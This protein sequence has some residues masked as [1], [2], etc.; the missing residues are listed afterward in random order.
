MLPAKLEMRVNPD[1]R[2]TAHLAAGGI[3]LTADL[4]Q[5]RILRRLHDRARAAAG[6]QAWPTAQVLPLA[7]W[8]EGEW[9]Q[10][11]MLR[12]ELPRV[13]PPVA[14]DWLWRRQVALAEPSLL[15]SADL[16]RR[17]RASWL[18]LQAHGSSLAAVTRWPLT[19]DQQAFLGWAQA[20]EK[21]LRERGA[22]DAAD[23]ARRFVDCSV[24][25]AAGPPILLA[26]FARVTPAEE[27]LFAAL[28]TAGRGIARAVATGTGGACSRHGARDPDAERDDM[29]AWLRA[30]V[31]ERPDGI[32]AVIVADLDASRG[33]LE[34]ALAASLQ[35]DLE[36]PGADR[37]ERV[38]DLAGGHTLAM[39]P[40][41]DAALSALAAAG[42]TIEWTT[43]S[44]LLRS[45]YVAGAAA[46][47]SSRVVADLAL[48]T[49]PGGIRTSGRWLA[50]CAARAGAVRFGAAADAAA[51]ALE[52]PRRRNA[53][54]WA[55]AFGQCLAAWGWPGDRPPGSRV[56]QAA[57]RLRELLRE[58]AALGEWAAGLSLGEALAELRRLAGRPFQPESGEPAVYV[59][60]RYDDP[61]VQLDSLWV[62]GLTA[63]AWPR[64]VAVDPLLPIEIQRE[65][66]LPGATPA[67]RVAEA[68]EVIG[69]WRARAQELVL[70]WPRL[71]NDS[72]ADASPLLPDDAP[73]WTPAARVANREQLCFAARRLDAVVEAPLPPLAGRR[74]K[75]GAKLLELQAQCAFRAFAELRLGAGRLEEPEAGFDRRLRGVVVHRA[76]QD[77][78]TRLGAQ[79]ALA[80]LDQ[81]ARGALVASAVD[82]ALGSC[83]P[84]DIGSRALDL[85]RDW[86]CQAIGH[87]LELDLS[88]PSF[89]VVEVERPM[90]VAIGGLELTL[91]IDRTDR[92]GEELVVI[93][94]KTGRPRDAAWR[95]ARMDAPQLPLYAVLH[96]ERPSGIAFAAL[97]LTRAYHVGVGRDGDAVPG[98][99]PAERFALTED[100]ESGFEW[101]A[102][103]ARWASW[104]GRLAADF[105]EGRAEVDPK[106]A[107]ATC[108][109]CHLG[110]LCRVQAEDPAELAEEGADDD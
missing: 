56:Y 63:G 48:R 91:R 38:F 85:E 107:A 21:E 69:S 13:L 51:L 106:L 23:L 79:S 57:H 22:C 82:R 37:D 99:M 31:A 98:M 78:W 6:Q 32:H 110:A 52:G 27:T 83:A 101:P 60:D 11:Q 64:P 19:R 50:G 90:E 61:G 55:E 84:A 36:L 39:Q 97:S 77:V 20:V 43:A 8:L 15:E 42:G 25:P 108:R 24:I 73:A 88:R 17:A 93:D 46:E 100:R 86:Q 12:P 47:R 41:V 45:P 62:A 109:L 74:M 3:V 76:L 70:S 35:P 10:Q 87:L 68:R 66:R 40:V 9:L 53:G 33:V 26:G 95:G 34:R 67:A 18:T 102:V 5:A 96:P 49:R 28:S 75:G 80:A 59:L 54:A 89:A 81:R 92:I 44:R 1:D 58:L 105:A 71:E 103:K 7:T 30:R 4:R 65:L 72:E 16:G 104:L 2:C 29:V 14:V 94:Y